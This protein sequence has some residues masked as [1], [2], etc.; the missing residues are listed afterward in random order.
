MEEGETLGLVGETGCGKSVTALSILRLIPQPPGKIEEGEILFDVPGDVL[1]EIESLEAQL[2]EVLPRV[3]GDVPE[4]RPPDLGPRRLREL[5]KFVAAKGTPTAPDVMTFRTAS[6]ALLKLKEPHDLVSMSDE[7]IR[8]IR[9]NKIA[10]IFQ[11]PM[12]SLNPVFPIG[13]QISE[14]ILLHQRDVVLKSLVQKMELEAERD[15]IADELEDADPAGQA[16]PKLLPEFKPRPRVT[17]IPAFA[18]IAVSGLWA[19]LWGV[20]LLGVTISGVDLGVAGG[21]VWPLL[22]LA[23]LA[24][25]ASVAVLQ[26]YPWARTA[27]ILVAFVNLMPH[28]FFVYNILRSF[29]TLPSDL[30]LGTLL[31]LSGIALFVAL[32]VVVE[33]YLLTA[34][35]KEE[36]IRTFVG[37]RSGWPATLHDA[38]GDVDS[39]SDVRDLVAA[40]RLEENLREALVTRLDKLMARVNKVL[41]VDEP[42]TGHFGPVIPRQAQLR[43][44][45]AICGW[46]PSEVAANLKE[47]LLADASAVGMSIAPEAIQWYPEGSSDLEIGFPEGTDP[48][49]AVGWV[50][51]ASNAGKSRPAI[52][53]IV[54]VDRTDASASHETEDAKERKSEGP[55]GQ[56]HVKI[57]KPRGSKGGP[58][59]RV[60]VLG[61]F[62]ARPLK[63]EGVRG[64]IQM[65]RRVKI[66]DPERIA[67]QYPYELSGGM[68]QRALIAIAL[69]CN[70][71][72]LIADEPTTALDV[73]IQAQ[74]LELI[75]DLKKSSGSTVLIIT[76]D[77]GII[78]EMCNRVCV[79]YA[80]HI[81]ED[82]SARAIFKAPLHPYTQ[83]LMKAIP[84]HAVKKD[85]LEIIKGSVPNLIYP[86]S[87]CRFHP[88]CPQVMPTCGWSPSEV[89]ANLKEVLLAD[90]A[91][92]GVTVNPEAIRWY[93]EES[94]ELEIG[95]P[96]GTDPAQAVEWIRKAVNVGKSRPAIRA[97]VS[98]DR[99]DAS[100][101]H[102]TEDEKERKSEGPRG[103]VRVEI[104]EPRKPPDVEVEPNHIVNCLLYEEG[105]KAPLAGGVR[106]A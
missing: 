15:A 59:R 12:Q 90:A 79:M 11:D 88:R 82:A 14:N 31:L 9:G 89:A 22:V 103:Q 80:G 86:P 28:L 49:Q 51:K 96:E 73:T 66:S 43:F 35:T 101:S 47:V 98:V 21:G 104:L 45:R 68:Q 32:T 97:V 2:H 10:M 67:G 36:A 84:S 93:P 54:S 3:L 25:L 95:F 57:L 7:K 100:A 34:L 40:S 56:V 91:A 13:D 18:W 87:G 75:R 64:A 33:V 52:R 42:I 39:L 24:I 69:S 85:E 41:P 58:L 78:A 94:T 17:T 72:L 37:R 61:R 48:T 50:R 30:P 19:L 8:T 53:A 65:L 20:F 1:A 106:G 38:E 63:A 4:A 60:P 26:Q 29:L 92:V 27:A 55:R 16:S 81:A 99:T 23:A 5:W 46:S 105:L 83:G 62:L 76:H 74:I 77:L 102:E 70:P 44:Y 71:R 6:V